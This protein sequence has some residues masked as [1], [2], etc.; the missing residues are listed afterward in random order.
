LRAWSR[1]AFWSGEKSK[2]TGSS[3]SAETYHGCA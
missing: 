1:S 3:A 2:F